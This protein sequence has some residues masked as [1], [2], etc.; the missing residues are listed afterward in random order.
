MM[1]LDWH[2]NILGDLI[3]FEGE[4]LIVGDVYVDCSEGDPVKCIGLLNHYVLKQHVEGMTQARD[5]ML[6]LTITR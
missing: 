1:F 2:F 3:D 5:H 4:L 6:D